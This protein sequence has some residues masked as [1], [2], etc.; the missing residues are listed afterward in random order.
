MVI[1]VSDTPAWLDESSDLE[2]AAQILNRLGG[3]VAVRSSAV[4]EDG[5]EASFAGQYGSYLDIGDPADLVA[6]IRRCVESGDSVSVRRYTDRA[7]I[8]GSEVAVIVQRMLAPKIAGVAFSVDPVSG[9]D[10][11]VIEAVSGVGERLLAG[12]QAGERWEVGGRLVCVTRRGVLDEDDARLVAERCREVAA[13][14]A[15]P[16]DI[17]WAR[18]R[19]VLY[20]L[21]ARPITTVP[22][23]P[24][25]RPPERQTFIREPRF[26][27][28]LHPLSFSTWLPRHG[29]VITEMFE[30]FGVPLA[31][32]DNRRFLGRVYGRSV[33][34]VGTEKDGPAPPPALMRILMSVHPSL[35]RRLRNA[36]AWNGEEKIAELMDRWEREGRGSIRAETLR[37]R[38]RDLSSLTDEGLTDHFDEVIHHLVETA[39]R[40]FEL[41]F[42]ALLIPTG[43]LGMFVEEHLGWP[44]G[45]VIGLVQGYG[46]SSTD[47]GVAV[48]A[49]YDALGPGGVERAATDLS[50]LLGRPETAEYLEQHGHR[51]VGDLSQPTDAEDP[52]RFVD[53]LRRLE[54]H[55]DHSA[56]PKRH[57]QELESRAVERL[58]EAR[59]VSEFQGLLGLAR[60]GRPYNDETELMTLDV[61][62][63]VRYAALEGAR[64]LQ[65]EGRILHEEDVFYLE[66]DELIGTLRAPSYRLPDIERR[67]REHRWAEANP[68]PDYLGPAP[69]PPPP[70]SAIPRK[71]RPTIGAVLWAGAALESSPAPSDE[72]SGGL[73][74]TP[75][76]PGVAA[77]TVRVI[78]SESDFDRIQAGDIVVCPTTVAAWSPIFGAIAGLVAEHGGPLSHP[79]TLAREYGL[80][81]VLGVAG[82]TDLLE[83][84]T[85]VR[86]DGGAGKVE[87]SPSI[88]D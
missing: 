5:P 43:R 27:R 32:Q 83:E 18:E 56:D 62:A 50:W 42:A 57:A 46:E 70:P 8:P 2:A 25:A 7:D 48:R 1:G 80:P 29:E 51:V 71:A 52:G 82:A 9:A 58:S 20:L 60:R 11:V 66:L 22:L 31:R 68:A 55:S 12:E 30:K 26:D 41:A 10:H 17:E 76:S 16:V 67:R 6:A 84:G 69:A 28:P 87:R 38:Q 45:E 19:G 61:L 21:Q 54:G 3:R 39:R 4:A 49:L 74:G 47:H 79:A 13:A 59:L 65:R 33:P 88:L 36:R 72:R 40:H 35:R 23:E 37:L 64:R 73:R 63:L 24:T 81:A 15:H 44:A 85:R 78:R 77:G 75:G 53:H 14:T 34:L 86:V